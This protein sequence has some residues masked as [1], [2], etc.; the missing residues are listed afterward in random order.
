MPAI[1]R[2]HGQDRG[3]LS[4]MTHEQSIVANGTKFR[5]LI[6]GWP[7]RPWLTCLHSLATRSELWDDQLGVL[8]G[9]FKSCGS[10][11]GDT[12]DRPRPQTPSALR[13]S[14]PT[15]WRSGMWSGARIRC[16]RP[17]ARRHDGPRACVGSWTARDTDRRSGLP[18]RRPGLLPHHVDGQAAHPGRTGNGCDCRPDPSHMADREDPRD[19]V[20]SGLARAPYDPR[21]L[22]RGLSGR[23]GGPARPE[24]QA[25]IDG[26]RMPD[27]FR[28]GA[29]P[30]VPIRLRCGR[31]RNLSGGRVSEIPRAAHLANLEN[32]EAFNEIIGAFLI[33]EGA[34][35][36][37]EG[38][39][40][41]KGSDCRA[42]LVGQA[43]RWRMHEKS[44]S[45]TSSR[46][47]RRRRQR[48]RSRRNTA[49][50]SPWSGT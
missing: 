18:R 22:R 37:Q 49:C 17:V 25:S 39:G 27:L 44:R 20:G 31:W 6:D 41:G 11:R 38:T 24:L 16:A 40:R 43:Y 23:D 9:H 12:E 29:P 32:P 48:S 19:P 36:K 47:L 2:H 3:R 45:W 46:L 33:G 50:V 13:T 1:I 21:D 15:W 10:T 30:M 14:R 7:E 35:V 42:W 4:A 28:G 34:D 5:I 8:T 26:D